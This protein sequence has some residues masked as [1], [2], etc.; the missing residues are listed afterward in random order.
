MLSQTIETYFLTIENTSRI[1]IRNLLN[2]RSGIFSFTNNPE[3]LDYNSKPKSQNEII[4]IITT[5][6]NIIDF[7]SKADYSNSNYVL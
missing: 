2:H 4:A 3:Y 1:T 5:G 6:K 7:N